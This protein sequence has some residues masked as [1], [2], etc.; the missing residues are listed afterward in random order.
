MCG[1]RREGGCGR[2]QLCVNR[3]ALETAGASASRLNE[4]CLELAEEGRKAKGRKKAKDAKDAKGTDEEPADKKQKGVAEKGC[5]FLRKRRAAVSELAEEAL[6]TPMDI[7]DLAA[8][9]VKRKAC[10]YYA[11]REAHPRADLIFAPYAAL[12]IREGGLYVWALA[13][14]T[15]SLEED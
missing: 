3:D 2:R 13:I 1:H 6:A 10:P 15:L 12:G 7:E 4:R 9:G 14:A 11:A 8:A 5:P